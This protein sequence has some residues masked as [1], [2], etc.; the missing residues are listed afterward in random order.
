MP[1]QPT[2]EGEKFE[3]WM[4][5]TRQGRRS[6]K[7]G[8]DSVKKNGPGFASRNGSGSPFELIAGIGKEDNINAYLHEKF[9]GLCLGGVNAD[10]ERRGNLGNLGDRV[11][12][13][14]HSLN[15]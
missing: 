12:D 14:E 8:N 4:Q 5:V 7:K 6:D 10:E 11:V 13:E 3:P 9:E 1:P 2:T 15:M